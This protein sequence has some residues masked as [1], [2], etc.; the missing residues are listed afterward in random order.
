MESCIFCE[1]PIDPASAICRRC[2]RVAQRGLF[3][4]SKPATLYDMPDEMPSESRC[5]RCGAPTITGQRFCRQCGVA[6][7]TF[8]TQPERQL[9]GQP[10]RSTGGEAE[11]LSSSAQAFPALPGAGGSWWET[12]TLPVVQASSHS[13]SSPGLLRRSLWIVL[14]LVVVGV[15]SL[16]AYLVL[17]AQ[18]RGPG[19]SVGSAGTPTTGAANGQTPPATAGPTGP[20]GVGY[21]HTNGTQIVDSLNQP[22][23]IAGINWFGFESKTY[24]AHG[25]GQRDYRDLLR[26]IKGLGYN[27]IRIPFSD[28]LFLSTSVPNGI[29]FNNGMNQDLQGLSGLQ[30]LD[31]MVDAAGQLGLRI[32]LDHH[33]V[34]AGSQTELWSSPN[35]SVACFEANW[36]MLARHYLGNT[37]VIGADLNNEPH[38]PACWGC[39]NPAVDWQMEAQKLG[40]ALLAINPHWL[41]FVEGIECYKGD[42]HWWGGNLEG[43]A[44]K[45]VQL[46]VPNQVVYSPHDYPPEVYNLHYFNAPNYPDNLPGIW[47]AHWGFIFKQGIAPI[48]LGEFGTLLSNKKDEQW[49]SSLVSYLGQGVRGMSWT[50]WALNPDSGDTGGILQNDWV[51]VNQNKQDYLTP[52]EFPLAGN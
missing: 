48:M 15:G 17:Y 43:V 12:P 16:G 13:I 26:Q 21:W 14:L 35:C 33:G 42:C 39:G 32:I 5:P 20:V 31:K 4:S 38:G 51:S 9:V 40:N 10:A 52:I 27:T 44:D 11:A 22:V 6:L 37:T 41:I 18:T 2:G 34:D 45:P 19:G 7:T 1:G 23:R 24:V 46:D 25:L 47:D 8:P 30:I 50:Y 28:E 49:F 3:D 29:S 36:Q